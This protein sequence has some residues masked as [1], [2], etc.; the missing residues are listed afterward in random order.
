PLTPEELKLRIAEVIEREG[1]AEPPPQ[2][3][4]ELGQRIADV[5]ERD[6][7]L[8]KEYWLLPA[9]IADGLGAEALYKYEAGEAFIAALGEC[10]GT[11]TVSDTSGKPPEPSKPTVRPMKAFVG[12]F[13]PPDLLN[14]T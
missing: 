6:A 4:Q 8:L 14:R 13:P 9:Y 7:I 5:L 3:S 10:S 2:T 12:H 11:Q 1:L